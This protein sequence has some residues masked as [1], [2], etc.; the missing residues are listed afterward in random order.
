MPVSCVVDLA[1]DGMKQP[2]TPEKIKDKD[3]IAQA[4]GEKDGGNDGDEGPSVEVKV[5]ENKDGAD[6]NTNK[7]K[8][9]AMETAGDNK[10]PGDKY[11]PKVS[12]NISERI[13]FF[14][15]HLCSCYP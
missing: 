4:T 12:A 10:P 11:S 3:Q 8:L 2:C 6:V 5:E 15:F 13:F 1:T 14:F 9:T 7:E